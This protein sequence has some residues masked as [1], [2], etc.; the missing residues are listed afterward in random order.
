MSC[1]TNSL[2]KTANISLPG[3]IIKLNS[4]L[5]MRQHKLFLPKTDL[6]AALLAPCFGGAAAAGD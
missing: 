4:R 2:V 3:G 6:F 5:A 1:L